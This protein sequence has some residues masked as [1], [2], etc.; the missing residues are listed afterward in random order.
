MVDTS[1]YFYACEFTVYTYKYYTFFR[2]ITLYKYILNLLSVGRMK[3]KIILVGL[4]KVR[5]LDIK[6][7]YQ[8]KHPNSMSLDDISLTVTNKQ[9]TQFEYRTP[10]RNYMVK[11][12]QSQLARPLTKCI[13]GHRIRFVSSK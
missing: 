6:K 13:H 4:C 5:R 8:K 1:P 7:K 12:R 2:Y 9:L 11:R 3:K 10:I